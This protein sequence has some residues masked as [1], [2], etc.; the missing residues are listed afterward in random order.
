MIYNFT[1]SHLQ[2]IAQIILICAFFTGCGYK[3]DP[4][5]TQNPSQTKDNK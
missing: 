3:A 1:R 5:Y 2:I 4:F